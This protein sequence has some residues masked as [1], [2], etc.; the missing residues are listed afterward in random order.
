MFRLVR[1]LSTHLWILVDLIFDM[2]NVTLCVC[3][4]IHKYIHIIF[5]VSVCAC[6]KERARFPK[7]YVPMS[8]GTKFK[9]IFPTTA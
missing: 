5:G 1:P 4:P 3:V 7:R 2:L 8:C 9:Y 6:V